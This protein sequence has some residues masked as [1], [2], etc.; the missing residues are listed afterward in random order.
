VKSNIVHAMAEVVSSWP[1]LGGPG[2]FMWD[3]WWTNWHWDRFFSK[4]LGFVLSVSFHCGSILIYCLGGE[5]KA[6]LW[7]QFRDVV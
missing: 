4:F 6:R 3:L 2:Q 7:P 1:H 5:Q